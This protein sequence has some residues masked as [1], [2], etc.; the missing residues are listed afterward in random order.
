MVDWDNLV[1]RAF[2][3]TYRGANS[4][5]LNHASFPTNAIATSAKML[6]N[7]I[8]LVKPTR[9]ILA[10][11]GGSAY[12]RG[13]FPEYKA[14][15]KP[16]PEYLTQQLPVTYSIVK[17]AGVEF[18][19]RDGEEGDDLIMTLA[20]RA[21][22]LRGVE[23]FVASHDKDFSQV[24]AENIIWLRPETG[25][26]ERVDSAGVVAKFGVPPSMMV[27]YLAMVKDVADN[28]PGI[29]GIGPVNAV[30]LLADSPSF[31]VLSAR[32]AEEKGWPLERATTELALN[33]KLIRFHEIA[34]L[35]TEHG[36]NLD[37]AIEKLE[38]LDCMEAVGIW[39]RIV[40]DFG[41][42]RRPAPPPASPS[43]AAAA[44]PPVKPKT[45][46]SELTFA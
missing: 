40:E 30:R 25:G 21:K 16:K 9:V 11:D 17:D 2:Y 18:L 1:S 46:Q 5:V 37:G 14:K 33:H 32:V 38:Q 19:H 13:F 7:V 36:A 45:V 44:A 6:R 10:L 29:A 3:A 35:A 23:V 27:S 31:E 15:R 34:G 24:V 43:P 8:S 22:G 28:T 4:P 41:G 39:R 12:R 20:N 26:W 42:S